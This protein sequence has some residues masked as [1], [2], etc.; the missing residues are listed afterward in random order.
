MLRKSNRGILTFESD[1]LSIELINYVE[2]EQPGYFESEKWKKRKDI[3][4]AYKDEREP[5]T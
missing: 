5:L 2:K 1:V 3:F 4:Q